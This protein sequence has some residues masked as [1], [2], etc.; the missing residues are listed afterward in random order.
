[1]PE[2]LKLMADCHC[3]PLWT[4]PDSDTDPEALPITPELRDRLQRW[5]AAFDATLN[6]D[7]PARG[8]FKTEDE[9]AEFLNKFYDE[10]ERIWLELQRQLK[11]DYRVVY[12]DARHSGFRIPEE[13]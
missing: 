9:R 2:T 11:P 1:M 4:H 13:P 5:A 7:D 10:G 6:M 12:R 8:N 3:W